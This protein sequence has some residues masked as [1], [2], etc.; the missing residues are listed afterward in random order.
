[1]INASLVYDLK[2]VLMG[3][4]LSHG[5]DVEAIV[6]A[7]PRSKYGYRKLL[8]KDDVIVGGT[9]LDDRRHY[10]AYRQLM[11]TRVKVTR[12]KDRL[13]HPDFDPNLALP[14]GSLDYYF[15]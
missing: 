4:F 7:A 1:M 11:Q 9:F 15:F 5:P 13:L 10:L 14:A 3:G 2:Y 12:L 6:D 8:I